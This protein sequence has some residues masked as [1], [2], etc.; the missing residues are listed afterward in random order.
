[1]STNMEEKWDSSYVSIFNIN[2][3]YS[4]KVI[5]KMEL[6]LKWSTNF[7][8]KEYSRHDSENFC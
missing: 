1:M 6:F 4:F 2:D 5:F 8:V 3:A 7:F